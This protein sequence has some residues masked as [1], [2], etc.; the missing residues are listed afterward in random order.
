[1]TL[2]LK[3]LNPYYGHHILRF[4]SLRLAS[5]GTNLNS[6]VQNPDRIISVPTVSVKW[7]LIPQDNVRLNMNNKNTSSSCNIGNRGSS[8]MYNSNKTDCQILTFKRAVF[9][10]VQRISRTKYVFSCAYSD[11]FYTNYL[12]CIQSRTAVHL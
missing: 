12:N 1:M 9:H 5:F 10:S 3:L 7:P 4:K 2:D 11:I 8:L 6:Y